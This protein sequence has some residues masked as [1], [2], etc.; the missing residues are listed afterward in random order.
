ML[1]EILQN[2]PKGVTVVQETDNNYSVYTPQDNI[3]TF[4]FHTRCVYSPDCQY[5][6]LF[7]IPGTRTII[8]YVFFFKDFSIIWHCH[9]Q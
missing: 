1:P 7:R 4:E 5:Y 3:L 2:L 8:G 6:D 9:Y